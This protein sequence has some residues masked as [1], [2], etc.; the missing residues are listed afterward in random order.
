MKCHEARLALLDAEPYELRGADDGELAT[1]LRGCAVCAADAAAILAR[2]DTLRAAVDE[3]VAAGVADAAGVAVAAGVARHRSPAEDDVA[4]HA[5]G[6]SPLR[7]H[8]S[9]RTLTRARVLVPLATAAG[10]AALV[11]IGSDE[12]PMPFGPRPDD[13]GFHVPHVDVPDAPVVNASGT[14]GVAVMRT[15]NPDITVVWNF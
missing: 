8:G 13:I 11:L 14:R 15:T 1:H 7:R 10:I 6:V 5:R 3:A 2:T 9:A 4:G 12:L